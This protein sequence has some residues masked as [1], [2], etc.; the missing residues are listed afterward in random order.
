[1]TS[2]DTR[3]MNASNLDGS[4]LDGPGL[5]GYVEDSVYPS[6]FHMAFSPPWVDRMLQHRNIAT[7]RQSGE[8]FTMADIGC[9]DGLGLILQAAAYPDC[10]FI[11]ID[12]MPAHIEHGNAIIAEL[13][14]SNI[15]LRCQTFKEA[16]ISGGIGADYVAV[17]GVLSW[18]SKE[19]QEALL[20]LISNIL[21]P[22]GVAVIGYNCLPGWE[23]I[24]AFQKLIR[25]LAANQPGTPTQ[26]FERAVERSRSASNAGMF[27]LDAHH[28]QWFDNQKDQFPDDYFAHEYLNEHW[29]P[30]WSG[31]VI[32]QAAAHGLDFQCSSMPQR[33][34]EDFILKAVQR[35]QL[36]DTLD[37]SAREIMADLFLN[38][39]FRTDIFAK[40]SPSISSD[41]ASKSHWHSGCWMAAPASDEAEYSIK[42]TA[43]TLNFDNECA[44]YIIDRLQAGPA[45]M[46]AIQKSGAP[47]TPADLENTADSLFLGG[48]IKPIDQRQDS[49]AVTEINTWLSDQEKNGST[50]NAIITPHGPV[51]V[52]RGDISRLLAED[53]FCRLVGL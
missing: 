22:G 39:W 43:G 19:N 9:G 53:E 16:L 50:I 24:V 37:L 11:G 4:N 46:A 28:F 40:P 3:S 45:T 48:L 30:L 38:C 13:G 41:S 49:L 25:S 51:S 35:K 34:R 42:T 47:G 12:A 36:E 29:Q 6:S 27:A 31:E 15:E 14:L 7:P 33:Q 1:M 10:R 52:P 5:E 23:P 32:A 8:S 44:H 17:Q 20:D 26:R 18:I 21:A 2:E